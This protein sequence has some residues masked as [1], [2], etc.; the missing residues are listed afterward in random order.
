L[1]RRIGTIALLVLATA[2]I[3]GCG[4]GGGPSSS[5]SSGTGTG[6]GVTTPATVAPN[7]ETNPSAFV[8]LGSVAKL[9]LVLTDSQ[10]LVLYGF[11]GD[12][13]TQSACYGRCAEVWPPLTTEGPPQPSNGAAASKLGTIKRSDGTMQ[14]TFA[15][16]P[17]YTYVAD[18]KPGEANGDGRSSFGGSWFALKGSGRPAG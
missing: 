13:G 7:P 2:L 12:S 15:G 5:G 6:T 8:S 9:G 14:V 17:L 11:E 1:S 4:G 3:S 18:K 10:G 16:Q